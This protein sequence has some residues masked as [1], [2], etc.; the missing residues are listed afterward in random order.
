M[1]AD[2]FLRMK[3]R[4]STSLSVILFILGEEKDVLDKLDFDEDPGINQETINE[5]KHNHDSPTQGLDTM[6]KVLLSGFNHSQ[7][8]SAIKD[9][10]KDFKVTDVTEVKENEL[11]SYEIS[12][13]DPR[14]L[15]KQMDG[16][17]LL[18]LAYTNSLNF[19]C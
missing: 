5:L 6:E 8:V 2:A 10:L 18:R 16:K 3:I 1:W 9:A 4:E 13:T 12:T 15:V 14:K 11:F 19:Q 17:E 7:S